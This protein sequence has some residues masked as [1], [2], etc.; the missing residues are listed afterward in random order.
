MRNRRRNK[1]CCCRA[2]A[3]RTH[4]ICRND[5]V[6]PVCRAPS[7]V[8]ARLFEIDMHYWHDYL[9]EGATAAAHSVANLTS[10]MTPIHALRDSVLLGCL[11][12]YQ[13]RQTYRLHQ[14]DVL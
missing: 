9:L 8:A 11:L 5:I 13:N 6:S 4:S 14:A 12:Q 7:N 2:I 1:P 10:A 3:D